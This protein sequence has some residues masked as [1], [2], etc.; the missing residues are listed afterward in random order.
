[1]ELE[2]QLKRY[3]GYSTFRPLQKE[4]V[5]SILEG[6]DTFALLPTGAGKSICFQLPALLLPGITIVVSPLI[7]LM[8][9]QVENLIKKGISATLISST[10]STDEAEGRLELIKLHKYKVIYV[11]PERLVNKKFLRV[12]KSIDISLVVVDEAHCIDM[13]GLT[14]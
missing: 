7:A 6:R 13:W 8:Q 5:S 2:K 1:M 3:F 10:L 4:I 12:C 14:N 11:A 9:D